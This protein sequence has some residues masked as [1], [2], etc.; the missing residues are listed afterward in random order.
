MW[1]PFDILYEDEHLI[2][3]NK[4]SGIMVHRTKITEDKVF[5]LQ[6]LR[7]QIGQRLYPVHR[8]DRGTSGALLMAKDSETASFVGQQFQER[9]VEKA[10]QAIVRGFLPLRG[11]IDY[12]LANRSPQEPQTA[13]TQY[14]RLAQ[15]EI[16]HA[17]G[18]YQTARYSL[19]LARPQSGKFHQIRRHFSHLR[20]PIIGDKKH[21][22]VKH[23]NYWR[24]QWEIRRLLL[25]A[26]HLSFAH[27]KRGKCSIQAPFPD[28]FMKALRLLAWEEFENYDNLS[29]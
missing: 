27:P 20:H 18:R 4:P 29:I 6:L 9:E 3:I 21:G 16:P 8:L 19:I 13:I 26:S 10:Y 11:T 24:D 12:A 28:D 23:N 14:Q 15:T 25:H 5:V 7:D 2:A 1:P 17:I 22:D